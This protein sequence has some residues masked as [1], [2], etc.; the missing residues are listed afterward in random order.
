M[1]PLNIPLPDRT[2]LPVFRQILGLLGW[3]AVTAVAAGL[4]S[5]ASI[6]ASAFYGQLAQP[7]WAPPAGWFG[8][9]WSALYLLM[10]VAAWL[11]WRAAGWHGARTA[12]T[13]YLAQLAV[14]ALWSWLF[15]GWHLG[16]LAFADVL[17][18]L[19]MV[20]AT[21]AAFWRV[22]P[23]AGALLA[24]YLLWVGFASALNFAV[25]QLNPGAL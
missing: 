7:S 2:R 12:L 5:A 1:T 24:P 8:P 13:L 23:L 3:L 10:A 19:A 15:F 16:A 22:R 21:L 4:G 9:V 6:Q 17:L 20:A 14:N 11:V 25:W 18:L